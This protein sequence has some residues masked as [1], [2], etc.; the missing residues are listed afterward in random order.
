MIFIMVGPQGSG[1]SSFCERMFVGRDRF[2]VISL[3]S[4]LEDA[5]GRYLWS[6]DRHEEACGWVACAAKIA[7]SRGTHVIVD[8]V[9]PSFASISRY[10]AIPEK[11]CDVAFIQCDAALDVCMNRQKHDAPE[12]HVRSAI[13][14][15]RSVANAAKKAGFPVLLKKEASCGAFWAEEDG[16]GFDLCDDSWGLEFVLKTERVARVLRE[17]YPLPHHPPDASCWYWR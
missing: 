10:L 3:D 11:L 4:F 15:C 8:D 12:D 16:G 1:K 7:H 6:P 17:R 14:G 9:H 5:E 2:L 13:L